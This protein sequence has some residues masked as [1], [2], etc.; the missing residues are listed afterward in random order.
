M[1][2]LFFQ[3][4]KGYIIRNVAI[5]TILLFMGGCT[6]KYIYKKY[7]IQPETEYGKLC[8]K[9]CKKDKIK[10]Q[11]KCNIKYDSCLLEAKKKAK[12]HIPIALK[13]Y[14]IKMFEYSRLK[15]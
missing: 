4:K 7:Y 10:C 9:S 15:G 14:N 1:N 2:F 6:P 11:E 8:I 3:I 13:E 5:V 12:Y